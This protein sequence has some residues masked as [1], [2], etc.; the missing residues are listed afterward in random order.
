[1]SALTMNVD[2]GAKIPVERG[3]EE[4]G[5]VEPTVA[6]AKEKKMEK[7][8]TVPLDPGTPFAEK[9]A[10]FGRAILP[11]LLGMLV[12]LGIWYIAT[13]K[14]GSI[15]GPLKTRDAAAVLPSTSRGRTTRALAGT[16]CP[17]CNASVSA[18]ALPRW[19]AFRSASSWAARLSWRPWSTRS[20]ASCARFRRWL[21]CRSACS[22]SSGLTRQRPTPFS[23]ARSGR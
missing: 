7:T 16:S 13:M 20:S 17:R 19:S 11:P 23:S 22:S 8:A 12:L 4:V 18:S 9:L 14:G 21:G 10:G 3:I 5:A 1:M 15:P 2:F 6:P